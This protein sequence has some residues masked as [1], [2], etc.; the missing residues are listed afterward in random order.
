MPTADRGAVRQSGAAGARKLEMAMQNALGR[1]DG[2]EKIPPGEC[3]RR[4][5]LDADSLVFCSIQIRAR[6]LQS[7]L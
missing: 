1:R 6:G 2:S 4:E 5:S 3:A 7:K